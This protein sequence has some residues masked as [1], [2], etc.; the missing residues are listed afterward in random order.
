MYLVVKFVYTKLKPQIRMFEPH[1]ITRHVFYYK[2]CLVI[3]CFVHNYC[4]VSVDNDN[5]NDNII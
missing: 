1:K 3:L 2:T 5:D 4:I